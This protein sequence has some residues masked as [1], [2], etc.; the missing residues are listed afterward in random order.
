[1]RVR[2][3]VIPPLGFAKLHEHQNFFSPDGLRRIL[4]R[5]GFDVLRVEQVAGHGMEGG[6][7]SIAALARVG[8]QP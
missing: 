4:T 3:G 2:V 7:A 6:G 5:G 1:M 8:S